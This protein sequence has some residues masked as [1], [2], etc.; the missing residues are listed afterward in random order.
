MNHR[1]MET[2]QFRLVQ[3]AIVIYDETFLLK[4][5]GEKTWDYLHTL[6]RK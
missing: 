1:V 6:L 4:T 3:F 2:F 5:K